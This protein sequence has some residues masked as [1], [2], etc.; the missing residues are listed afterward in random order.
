[1]DETK[2]YSCLQVMSGPRMPKGMNCGKFVDSTVFERL[3]EGNLDTGPGD[4][5]FCF[6]HMDSTPSR[7]GEDENGITMGSPEYS[8]LKQRAL[9][10]R[11]LAVLSSFAAANMDL[12]PGAIDICNFE[13]TAFP[14]AKSAGVDGGKTGFVVR[15]SNALEDLLNLF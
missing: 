15:K 14:E 1:M 12:H 7:S 11:H 9:G 6:G 8:E 3:L 13:A 5:L 10:K 4:R 2:V